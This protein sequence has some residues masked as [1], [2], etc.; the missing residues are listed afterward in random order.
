MI[1]F[2]CVSGGIEVIDLRTEK[3][4][5]LRGVPDVPGIP[6]RRCGRRL[7]VSTVWRWAMRGVRGRR[8]E[9]VMCGAQR[10]TSLAALQRFFSNESGEL[11]SQAPS[12]MNPI[13]E[14]QRH[15]DVQQKLT[16]LGI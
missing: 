14:T 12:S 3:L 8:L 16:N 1:T 11:A 4:I 7:N 2:S 9:T 6:T 5:P 10:C 13:R 15:R